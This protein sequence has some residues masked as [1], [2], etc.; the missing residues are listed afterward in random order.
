MGGLPGLPPPGYLG[1]S[2]AAGSTSLGLEG[3]PPP[4]YL[5]QEP[6]KEDPGVLLS[7]ASGGLSGVAGLGDLADLAYQ[8]NPFG[9]GMMGQRPELGAGKALRSTFDYLIGVDN[10]TKIGDDTLSYKIASYLPGMAMGP[11][12]LI[13]GG[14]TATATNLAKLLGGT[15][16]TGTGGF[17]G[18]EVG[19]PVGEI[20]GAVAAGQI[21]AAASAL[22]R[23]AG[24]IYNALNPSSEILASKGDEL[25]GEL[26]SKY[27]KPE[28]VLNRIIDIEKKPALPWAA[29]APV[30]EQINDPGLALLSKTLTKTN[31]E[32]RAIADAMEANRSSD[33]MLGF[34]KAQGPVSATP[35]EA[36]KIIRAGLAEGEGALSKQ[37]DAAYTAAKSAK[38]TVPIQSAKMSVQDVIKQE[39]TAGRTVD[40]TTQAVINKV[41]KLPANASVDQLITARRRVGELI[42]D[43]RSKGQL[44]TDEATGY[45]V[46]TKLFGALDEAEKA[47]ITSGKREVTKSG[48]V[49]GLTATEQKAIQGARE[50]R[51][52]KGD[53]YEDLATGE[54]LRKS[55]FNKYDIVDSKVLGKVISGP[56]E[57]R[58][59]MKGLKTNLPSGD[60]GTKT[61]QASLMEELKTR[62]TNASTGK[63]EIASF[64]RNWRNMKNVAKEVLTRDQL[65]AVMQ[66]RADLLSAGKYERMA[67]RSSVG[68]SVT[69]EG[70]GAAAF[71]KNTLSDGAKSKIPFVSNLFKSISDKQAALI[72]EKADEALIS[73][74]FDRKYAKDFL[75]KLNKQSATKLS[76][77]VASYA[78]PQSLVASIPS[79]DSSEDEKKSVV[80]EAITRAEKKMENSK[81]KAEIEATVEEG[82]SISEHVGTLFSEKAHD[83]AQSLRS[84]VVAQESSK[85]PNAISNKGAKGL[86]Q[87][88]DA[89][90]EEWHGKLG[91]QEK[92]DPFNPEQNEKIG[93]AYLAYLLDQFDLDQELALTAYNSGIGRVSQLLK[94]TG[95]TKLSDI[96]ENLGPDGKAYAKKVLSR[97]SVA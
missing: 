37:V 86:M 23:G 31:P 45:K 54:I 77:E 88:M 71:I 58:L 82:P 89:T 2:S 39:M 83:L 50:L 40:A 13:K 34:L 26:L 24:S 85:N 60:K 33:R 80:T 3:L 94:K 65:K 41:V 79:E 69:T 52:K 4:G 67:A 42:G 62:S 78:L 38:G 46:A 18:N 9:G 10:S 25:A 8:Y 29:N 17:V 7:A 16:I 36:G 72:R 47:A 1:A 55:G 12:N 48:I 70:L 43:F 96:I 20:V 15:A 92:Y 59:V 84:K 57:A 49:K 22:K 51:I 73:L 21:P 87:L 30:A 19:G 74:S 11:G 28:Q 91:V 44:T 27:T 76:K 35:E 75:T 90:G 66:T 68:Q 95:G 97:S 81:S 93:T 53:L 14:A 6:E 5:K 61:L 63:F 56:E 32:A 64:A